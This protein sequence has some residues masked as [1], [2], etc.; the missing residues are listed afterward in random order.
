[1][2]A[3]GFKTAKVT[4][5]LLDPSGAV[6]A[7][8]GVGSDED[9]WLDL[10]P[11]GPWGDY[12]VQMV[13][14]DGAGKS[15]EP[16]EAQFHRPQTPG[17]ALKPDDHR[18]RVLPPF[19]PVTVELRAGK[20]TLGAWGRAY[21]YGDAMLPASIAAGGSEDLLAGPMTIVADGEAL[22][23][24][25]IRIGA[26][27]DVRVD[28]T[29]AAGCG[30]LD[31]SGSFWFEYDGMSYHTLKLSAK[32]R[33]REVVLRIP[34][35]PE[36]AQY[37]HITGGVMSIGGG[38]T[39]PIDKSV[40]Y[41]FLPVVWIGDFE[42][43]LC[44]FTESRSHLHIVRRDLYHFDVQDK[45]TTFRVHLAEN[46]DPGETVT[47]KFGLLATPVKPLHPRHPLN[48]FVY[49][50]ALHQQPPATDPIYS[51]VFW[52]YHG[53]FLDIPQWS[54]SKR[55]IVKLEQAFRERQEKFAP[56]TLIPYLDPYT[57]T[58]EYPAARH[59]VREWEML[60]AQHRPP[61]QRP[62]G[63]KETRTFQELWMSPG[64]ESF[65]RYFAHRVAG[66]IER[67]KLRGLYFDFGTALPDS[68]RYHGADGG[69]PLLALRDFYRRLVNEF[70]TAGVRDYVIIA[71]NSKS[72]QIPGLTFVTHFYNGEH[73]RQKTSD[74]LH[75]GRDYLDRLPLYYFGIEHSGLPWGIHGNMLVEF[76]EA[77]S[78]I[79]SI[80]APN[81][82]VTEYLWDRTPS[83][84]MPI[85]LHGSLPASG[86]TSHFYYKHVVNVLEQFDIP[87]AEFCP[88]WRNRHLVQ[89]NND[90]FRVSAYS[91]PES[92]H[93]LLV[94]GNLSEQA[95][96]ATIR[97]DLRD[98]FD[99]NS[100]E[101][102]GMR[103]VQ[104]KG[105]LMRVSE[106]IGFR[107]ARLLDVQP[108]SIRV[109]VRGHAMALIEAA[110]HELL[111]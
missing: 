9:L 86:R 55:A 79:N 89:V 67:T 52:S 39:A 110:G 24:Q 15:S 21:R 58:T 60:P 99:W 72:V 59:Y 2:K 29:T 23:D 28:A 40:R 109:W 1:L 68:N 57:L 88:Y 34:F 91:R 44:W 38:F 50:A 63:P 97:F 14:I 30:K 35:K 101:F 82:T 102:R 27:S 6:I 25:S 70:V 69:Y 7:E 73:H 92:P 22:T 51:H 56:A 106:R 74:T 66:L 5:R 32:E 78:L 46:L 94:V 33:V 111:R 64:S 49:S 98:F 42:R 61:T 83:A 36:H 45:V 85:L 31:A 16:S 108:R 81:E 43:G 13:A 17:W 105:E 75:E 93:V 87:T 20:A 10:S 103:K 3:T 84:L 104:K 4:V 11:E 90:D 47:V 76:P 95:G 8:E 62:V 41:A 80:G 107:D 77:R 65:R 19:E 71:H 54:P 100:S 12:R 96:E 37:T 53:W 18:D 26:T 48:A